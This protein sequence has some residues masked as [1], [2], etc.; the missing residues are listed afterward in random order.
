MHLVHAGKQWSCRADLAVPDS[1][2]A[3]SKNLSNREG[4]S[5]AHSHSLSPSRRPDMNEIL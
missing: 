5:I 3:G 4:A 1:G 2:L